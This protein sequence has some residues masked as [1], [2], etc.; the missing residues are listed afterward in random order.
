M[1]TQKLFIQCNFC[2]SENFYFLDV[3]KTDP[4]LFFYSFTHIEIK[5]FL[6]KD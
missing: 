3:E 4:V 5:I 2:T 1:D 6:Q